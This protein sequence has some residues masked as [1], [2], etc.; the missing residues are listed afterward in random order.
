MMRLED[1]VLDVRQV[2]EG[3]SEEIRQGK[4]IDLIDSN[5]LLD[6]NELVSNDEDNSI[7][8]D[9]VLDVISAFFGHDTENTTNANEKSGEITKAHNDISEEITND[10]KIINAAAKQIDSRNNNSFE[11][12]AR[13]KL[14]STPMKAKLH[15]NGRVLDVPG[16]LDFSNAVFDEK[17]GKL[18][19]EK[20]EEIES[21]EKSPVLECNHK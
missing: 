13:L 6:Y 7:S 18:C 1:K 2:L 8:N 4:S 15:R 17:L 21:V 11:K 20:Q 12:L 19:M 3:F 9:P 5:E 16:G 14:P 10:D